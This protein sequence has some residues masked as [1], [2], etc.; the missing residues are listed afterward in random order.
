M[1]G[2]PERLLR[3]SDLRPGESLPSFLAR[4]AQLNHYDPP[5]ILDGL[6]LGYGKAREQAQ[7]PVSIETF[8]RLA[9]LTGVDPTALCAATAHRFA[10]VLTPPG[11][12]LHAWRLPDGQAVSYLTLGNLSKQV[13]RESAAQFCPDCLQE[14]AYHRLVWIPVAVSACLRHQR[15]LVDRCPNCRASVTIRSVVDARCGTCQADLTQA[16]VIPIGADALGRLSQQVLQAWLMGTPLPDNLSARALPDQPPAILY[17]VMDGLRFSI[18]NVRPGWRHLHKIAGG[19]PRL[20]F[21]RVVAQQPLRP[22]QSYRLFATAFKALLN[23]P[24]GFFA[25]LQA[26]W[27]HGETQGAS[28]PY[29][30]LGILYAQWLGKKWQPPA[31]QFV[32]DAFAEYLV[33]RYADSMSSLHPHWH[34]GQL[35]WADHFA[36]AT[37]EDAARL[38]H[39]SPEMVERLAWL[40]RLVFLGPQARFGSHHQFVRRVEVL[41]LQRKWH[42]AL[43]LQEAACWLGMSADVVRELVAAGLLTRVPGARPP[44]A[45]PT[46]QPSVGQGV[47]AHRPSTRRSGMGKRSGTAKR[48]LDANGAA[49]GLVSRQS[50]ADLWS[51]VMTKAQFALTPLPELIDL[52]EAMSMLSTVGLNAAGVIARVARGE[53]RAYRPQSFFWGFEA[54]LFSPPDLQMCVQVGKTKTRR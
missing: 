33:N 43:P 41:T 23:W 4:L 16:P 15:V 7:R 29:A 18:L 17:R 28:R 45:P 26:Y 25:F 50:V 3:R 42:E 52:Q 44:G 38:L 30:E 46:L 22:D 48:G 40:G 2:C 47:A 9:L 1:T 6:C 24:D 53:L 39:T 35:A 37:I 32:Q 36:Y 11:S 19:P 51:T 8:E 49:H 21:P 20:P 10:P 34:C 31:F 5:S 12:T 13:R 14:G 54:L 27:R